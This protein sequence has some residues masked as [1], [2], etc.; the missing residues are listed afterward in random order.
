MIIGNKSQMS[1]YEFE[2]EKEKIINLDIQT[3]N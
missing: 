1:Q 2:K 3:V